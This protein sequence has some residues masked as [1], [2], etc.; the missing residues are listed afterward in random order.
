M[1][2]DSY[3][4]DIQQSVGKMEEKMAKKGGAPARMLNVL[5][6]N[7]PDEAIEVLCHAAT[8]G[9]PKGVGEVIIIIQAC[10]G[11]SNALQS[12]R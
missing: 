10:R 11:R 6:C 7:L 12:R 1:V 9:A 4:T 8:K 5:A 3:F 2:L